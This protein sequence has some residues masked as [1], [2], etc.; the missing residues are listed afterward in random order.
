[1]PRAASSAF[2][3]PKR[4]LQSELPDSGS[5]ASSTRSPFAKR[6]GRELASSSQAITSGAGPAWPT[7]ADSTAHERA[8]A[9]GR[10]A[11]CAPRSFRTTANGTASSA[12]NRAVPSAARGAA[13]E[14]PPPPRRR[15][16]PAPREARAPSRSGTRR[17]EPG[18]AVHVGV[19]R[20]RHAERHRAALAHVPVE[21]ARER[22]VARRGRGCAGRPGT[23]ARSTPSLPRTT[24]ANQVSSARP[25]KGTVTRDVLALRRPARRRARSRC[26]MSKCRR[27]PRRVAGLQS[28]SSVGRESASPCRGR[29]PPGSTTTALTLPPRSR[30]SRCVS[31]C[32]QSRRLHADLEI[33]VAVAARDDVGAA[34]EVRSATAPEPS[35]ASRRVC[36]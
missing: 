14:A 21:Q 2:G 4:F 34:A 35:A 33:H 28:P 17:L 30:R 36:T 26:V 5:S 27:R 16:A 22:G 11:R 24:T 3:S 9:A 15:A 12:C 1:M 31:N 8:P 20:V 32:A 25:V 23:S 6:G 7:S 10:R 13:A 18:H 19:E 29:A